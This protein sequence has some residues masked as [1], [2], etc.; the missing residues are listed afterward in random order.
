MQNACF[1]CNLLCEL[2]GTMSRAAAANSQKASQ[3]A[4]IADKKER[5][6]DLLAMGVT[7]T[8]KKQMAGDTLLCTVCKATALGPTTACSCPGGRSKPASDYDTTADL[9]AAAQARHAQGQEVKRGAQQ[10][11]QSAVQAAKAKK[12]AGN[13]DRTWCTATPCTLLSV[14][15]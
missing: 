3:K 12:K 4:A 5:Q 10:G 2:T 14:H 13:R 1:G 8:M 9:L 15:C 7:S 6:A 11:Q